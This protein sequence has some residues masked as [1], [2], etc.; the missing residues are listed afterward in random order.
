MHC[1]P[2]KYPEQE[3]EVK[4]LK[5]RMT[6]YNLILQLYSSLLWNEGLY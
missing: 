4:E 3:K 2:D 6:V 1:I 5:G